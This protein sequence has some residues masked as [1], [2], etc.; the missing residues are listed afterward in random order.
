M[1][2]KYP[3]I[4]D[5]IIQ[6]LSIDF[7]LCVKPGLA[8]EYKDARTSGRMHNM[9]I[10]TELSQRTALQDAGSYSARH[11][12]L[13]QGFKWFKVASSIPSILVMNP[14]VSTVMRTN[15]RVAFWVSVSRWF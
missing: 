7:S 13:S 1:N 11:D 3:S 15:Q 5:V 8:N 2:E 10:N 12:D 14:S 9:E 4:D 6:R